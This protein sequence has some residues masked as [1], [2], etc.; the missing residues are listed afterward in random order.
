MSRR[1]TLKA[2]EM[3]TISLVSQPVVRFTD[4]KRK[5]G[6]TASESVTGGPNPHLEAVL[7]VAGAT[8]GEWVVP[9]DDEELI[10]R[11]DHWMPYRAKRQGIV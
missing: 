11:D 1:G 7:G 2:N 6:R 5:Y 9:G 4:W 10:I 8:I 3:P